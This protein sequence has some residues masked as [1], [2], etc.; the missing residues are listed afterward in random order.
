MKEELIR[1]YL[2]SI[3]FE[4]DDWKLS[5][6]REGMKIFLGEIPSIDVQYEKDS[7]LNEESG[8]SEV[9]EKVKKISIVFTDDSDKFK[10]IEFLVDTPK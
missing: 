10:K 3:D 6:M 1:K 2:L 7:M 4:N 8:E 5:D 9:I